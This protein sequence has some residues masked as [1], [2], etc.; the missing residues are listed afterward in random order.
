MQLQD[1]MQTNYSKDDL[2]SNVDQLIDAYRNGKLGGEFM[3]EDARP[4]EIELNSRENYLFLTL[5]MALNYQR[6]SY[7]LWEAAAK[8]YLDSETNDVFYP[9]KVVSMTVDALREKLVK[10]KL[11]LQPNKNIEIWSRISKILNQEFESDV[12]ILLEECDNDVEQITKIITVDH[13]KGF[14]YL[15]GQKIFNYWLYVLGDYTPTVLSNK[16]LITVAPDTHVMQASLRLGLVS[17][18]IKTIS[19]DRSLVANAWK[20]A[21]KGTK[22]SSIDVHTPMWL[23][24]RKGFP[25]IDEL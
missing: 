16:D 4:T 10:H 14:P 8:T 22:Y 25:S 3:P 13:K 7:K 12:R 5:P 18:D 19:K 24:S 6:D 17:G 23:W 20:D 11:A 2:L 15:S 9:E 1:N 21:L